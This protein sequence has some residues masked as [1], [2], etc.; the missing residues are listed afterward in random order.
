V[1]LAALAARAA[2]K[3]SPEEFLARV[4]ERRR[5]FDG[6]LDDETLGLLVLD[7]LGLN[8][9]AILRVADLEGRAEATVVVDVVR[10]NPAREFERERGTGRV[11]N[12]DV[13][14][15]TGAARLVLW[16]RDCRHAEDGDLR[17][18]RRVKIVNARVKSSKWGLELHA[19]PW[20]TF[21][22]EG[23][24]DAAH[25]KLLLDTRADFDPLTNSASA[26]AGAEAR[27]A[28]ASTTPARQ[29]TLVPPPTFTPL[30]ALPNDR[31]AVDVR[32]RVLQVSPTRT[33]QR[34]DGSV[35]FVANVVLE[36]GTGRA[37]LVLWDEAVRAVRSVA[38][39]TTVTVRD[40]QLREK[41]GRLELH[42]G[43]STKIERA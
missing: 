39:G 41:E 19:G 8:E 28:A 13:R 26:P 14:D 2:A 6:L 12:V 29:T 27:P 21:E 7:E 37:Q 35:G 16:N 22:V 4:E 31:P 1:D 3:L 9:G 15:A 42:A 36:D 17:E 5:E 34:K 38:I 18:G 23:A 40:A 24:V 33:F 11:L 20:T 25:R 30:G 43:R 32:G 10:V